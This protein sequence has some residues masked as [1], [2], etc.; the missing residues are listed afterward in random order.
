MPQAH[1][2]PAK[3]QLALRRI[4]N[5]RVAHLYGCSEAFVGRILN[6]YVRPPLRFRSFLSALL[7]VPEAQLFHTD[8]SGA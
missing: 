8:G 5:R 2:Q 7:E 4:T 3:G 1:A 6:G